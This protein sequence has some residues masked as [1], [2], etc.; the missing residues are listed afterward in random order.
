MS[1]RAPRPA[2][3]PD[4]T[5]YPESDDMGESTLELLIRLTLVPLLARYL[6]QK[7]APPFVG[8]NQ[9]IYGRRYEPTCSVAPDVYVLPGLAPEAAPRSIKV[10]ETGH[11]PSWALEVVSL[12]KAKDYLRAPLRYEEL[13]VKELVIFDPAPARETGVR[14][15]VYRRR[16]RGGFGR[17]SL[18]DEDRVFSRVLGCWLRV[19]PEGGSV[20]LRLGTG[21]DGD[22]LFPTAE[23][24]E[25]A[26]AETERARADAAEADVARLRALLARRGKR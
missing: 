13:G 19:V 9:F 25:R 8:G 23:E 11:A 26:R 22:E 2:V 18:S 14:W 21:K 10:W 7:G 3:A 15:Q 20:R 5:V 16:A 4:P 1:Q 6:K 24:A 17:A 12:D